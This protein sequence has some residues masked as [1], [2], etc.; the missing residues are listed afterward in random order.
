M[1]KKIVNINKLSEERKRNAK[2][3]ALM[4]N[5]GGCGKT[6][7]ALALGM[8]F[9]RTGKNVLFWDNDPQ[10]NL[11]QRLG[12]ADDLRKD[13]R[14]NKMFESGGSNDMISSIADFPYL[15]RLRGAGSK[16]GNIGIIGGAHNAEVK[17]KAFKSSLELGTEE[18]EHR[19]IYR[20]FREKIDFFK[21]YY[22]YIIIDTAPA[23]EGNELNMMT[24]RSANEIIYPID[25]I[26]AALGV[27]SIITWMESQIK[28]LDVKPNGLFVMVK[29]QDDTKKI[30][31]DN[32]EARVRNAVY[33]IMKESFGA[34]VCDIGVKE[35]P[36][37]RASL[38]GFGSRT[39]YTELCEEIDGK[40]G[41]DR[42][43]IFEYAAQNGFYKTM[44]DRLNSLS[45]KIAARRPKFKD[46]KYE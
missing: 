7:T 25:G 9:A 23:L 30:G 24:L 37:L 40:L 2:S 42:P 16:P 29:Y 39:R 12:L 43:N 32:P 27:K 14:L 26:E 6:T 38:P 4:N 18:L 28:Y 19:D 3:I 35:I 11:S 5:K 1:G 22:D 20:F 45:F 17:A 15:M 36:S 31:L 13:R 44:D 33:R 46:A 41:K 34:F 8:Y 21:N 10:S